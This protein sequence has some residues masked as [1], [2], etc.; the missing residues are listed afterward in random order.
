MRRALTYLAF[1]ALILGAV[2]CKAEEDFGTKGGEV[3]TKAELKRIEDNPN[4]PPQAKAAAL[5]QLKAHQQGAPTPDK[6]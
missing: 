5:A 4:M 2:G 6:K 3:D 1:A